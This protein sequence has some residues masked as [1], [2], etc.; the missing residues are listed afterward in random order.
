M[1]GPYD[2]YPGVDA[3]YNFP[4][5]IRAALK[6]GSEFSPLFD[7]ARIVGKKFSTFD[8]MIADTSL[9]NGDLATV[10][11]YDMGSGLLHRY[12]TWQKTNNVWMPI[13]TIQTESTGAGN[14]KATVK[15]I[16]AMAA[17]N[18]TKMYI[19]FG[20]HAVNYFGGQDVVWN[21]Q[22][23]LPSRN[24]TEAELNASF[25]T[26][27]VDSVKVP[28]DS[29]ITLCFSSGAWRFWDF[30]NNWL[31]AAYDNQADTGYDSGPGINAVS[32]RG[33][34]LTFN[35][36]VYS[37]NQRQNGQWFGQMRTGYR[38]LD[39]SYAQTVANSYNGGYG[40]AIALIDSNGGLQFAVGGT[41]GSTNAIRG[42][43]SYRIA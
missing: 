15:L 14:L 12:S 4:P 5:E 29:G 7:V 17:A 20:T 1:A 23:W 31:V 9:A 30:P 16:S 33:G 21:G 3:G 22:F 6:A 34:L 36:S 18:S 42:T 43:L 2:I 35:F 26:D 11:R 27:L 8:L 19:P 40:T 10:T 24:I 37:G 41:H 28:Q 39:G 32:V 13:G 38:P 25:T